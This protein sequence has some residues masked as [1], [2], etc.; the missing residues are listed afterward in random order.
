MTAAP[1]R[2]RDRVR[3]VWVTAVGGRVDHAVTAD[4]LATGL[5]SRACA[6][7]VGVCG[8]RFL[9]APL[10]ANPGA[11]CMSC[12]RRL[13]AEGLIRRRDKWVA[14]PSSASGRWLATLLSQSPVALPR[15]SS[16]TGGRPVPAFGETPTP[17]RLGVSP[18]SH[19]SGRRDQA[20]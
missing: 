4:D 7:V 6:G 14:L 15:R 2:A 13:R 9:P 12:A 1:T 16:P 19:P 10:V 3:V 5:G 8:L 18:R 20:C 11:T 17:V